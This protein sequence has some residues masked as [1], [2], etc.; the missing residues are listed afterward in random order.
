MKKI[1]I[2][3][4]KLK[5]LKA[6]EINPK[7]DSHHN[8]IKYLE[9]EWWYFDAIF[10][11]GY[12]IH[13][14]FRTYHIRKIGLVQ[15]RIDIYKDGKLVSKKL[16]IDF[17]SKFFVDQNFPTIKIDND[18]IVHFDK[19]AYQN[20]KEWKYIIKLFIKGNQI[21][22]LFRGITKGWKIET[23]DTCW[24][25]TLPKA[26][27]TGE[28]KINDKKIQC[29]GIGYHD[30]NWGYSPIT[31]MNNLG[32]YWGRAGTET[33]N[34]TWAKTIKDKSKKDIIS[35]FNKDYD[36]FYNINPEKVEISTVNYELKNRKKIPKV[37][38][39]KI[40]DETTNNF[41]I[42]C[43]VKMEIVDVQYI[44]IFTIKYWRYHILTSGEISIG[45]HFEKF[46][47][48]P[49]IIELLKFKN[50]EIE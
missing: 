8:N 30:H 47:N 37:I 7:D 4:P 11:N 16:K 42:S 35:V 39:L 12:S 46:Y 34:I 27:V 43:E 1:N 20:N 9:I 22:L 5:F 6:V 14:G 40:N 41:N 10:E 18:T 25:V 21:D 44:R 36:T 3:Q 29:N 23:S 31:A 13:I 15:S 2:N 48:K 19:D 33:M 26:I 17:F 45:N 24:A 50:M 38:N 49:Q 28:I 32:W